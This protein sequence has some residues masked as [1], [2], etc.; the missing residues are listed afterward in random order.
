MN[1]DLIG[2]SLNLIIKNNH[3]NKYYLTTLEDHK[4]LGFVRDKYVNA[5]VIVYVLWAAHTGNRET[6]PEEV[7]VKVGSGVLINADLFKRFIEQHQSSLDY[8]R[9]KHGREYTLFG[10]CAC[11]VACPSSRTFLG[12]PV[13]Q[14]TVQKSL[15]LNELIIPDVASI[16]REKLIS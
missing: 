14:A 3:P 5:T 11:G 13:C 2:D 10:K 16:I 9:V 6:L 8:L 4:I 1:C 15:L 7:G 12:P